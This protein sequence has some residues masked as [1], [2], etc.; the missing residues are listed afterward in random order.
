MQAVTVKHL[1]AT[2]HRPSRWV[3][4]CRAFK[5]TLS[6]DSFVGAN[7]AFAEAIKRFKA[8][9]VEEYGPAGFET[10]WNGPWAQGETYEGTTVFVNLNG[11]GLTNY[12]PEQFAIINN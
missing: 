8:D 10:V 4:R 9:L 11:T 3:V 1:P 2:N 6:D 7:F 5:E 12:P